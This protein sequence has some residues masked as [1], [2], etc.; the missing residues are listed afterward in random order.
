MA[1]LNAPFNCDASLRCMECGVDTGVPINAT[2]NN[3]MMQ[4]SLG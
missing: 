1:M 2:L 3:T 4:Q